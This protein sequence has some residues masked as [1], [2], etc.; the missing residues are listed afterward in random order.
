MRSH[1]AIIL[2]C[3]LIVLAMM[4]WIVSS[5]A[6]RP[7]LP[8]ELRQER[9]N[10]TATVSA[11]QGATIEALR[12]APS[13]PKVIIIGT[14]TPARYTKG[15]VPSPAIHTRS[16]ATPGSSQTSEGAVPRSTMM[17]TPTGT[18]AEPSS[19]ITVNT[20]V[21]VE[22]PTLTP[23][24]VVVR[25]EASPEGL[26]EVPIETPTVSATESI[27]DTLS[28]ALPSGLVDTED[29]ITEEMLTEQVKRDAGDYSL[30]DLS[31]KLTSDGISAIALVTIFPGIK[32][33]IEA[34]GTFAV[35]N[36]SLVIKVSSIRF[37]GLDVTERYRGQLESSINSS[38]YRLLPQRYVQSY[39]LEDGEIHVYSKVKP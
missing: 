38:L 16:I 26:I 4:P 32:R 28:P 12:R 29:V 9:E 2:V 19:I 7:L 25:S 33:R 8:D 30:S 34:N 15:P 36:Y 31:I 5:C 35:E 10:Y 39:E 24:R 17:A 22:S 14:V 23:R 20:V 1:V 6:Q 27:T 37:D 13:T 3:V 18:P 11:A 21:V